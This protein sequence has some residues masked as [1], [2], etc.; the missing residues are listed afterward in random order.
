V[1]Q[2][3]IEEEGSNAG[4]DRSDDWSLEDLTAE[5]EAGY[6]ELE[7]LA[8]LEVPRFQ[9]DYEAE[10]EV[11]LTTTAIA[12]VQAY[13]SVVDPAGDHS[14]LGYFMPRVLR[15]A[16]ETG[17]W[18][19]AAETIV[20]L[21]NFRSENWSRTAF[22][23]EI[24]QAISIARFVTLLDQQDDNG[25][26]EFIGLAESLETIGLDLVLS[27]LAE[28]QTRRHR[29]VLCRVV[30]E[31]AGEE[32]KRL[33]AWIVDPRWHVVRNIAYILGQIGTQA[34]LPLLATLLEHPE[35]RV[36]HEAVSALGRID[37]WHTRSIFRKLLEH[38]DPKIFVSAVT[39][40]ALCRDHELSRLFVQFMTHPDFS[41][42][43]DVERRAI[44]RAIGQTGGN[45]VVRDLES[46][47]H[48]GSWLARNAEE[49]RQ[50]VARC[51]ADIGG[52][53][54][55]G[56]LERAL[57]SRRSPVRRAAEIALAVFDRPRGKAA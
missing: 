52:G 1:S 39:Q 57:Q 45:E 32:P 2:A 55:R 29:R 16:L 53:D 15:E 33:G 24:L 20:I 48:R 21:E 28:I 8:V 42:R 36:Q 43:S 18:H 3:S 25:L 31:W 54:A 51:L 37:P 22:Q 14:E 38:R 50:E 56:A 40:L 6:A 35:P 4:T 46:E 41:R 12:L 30:E 7:Q 26:A 34:T 19:E 27:V 9:R 5:V 44:Y 17:R 47:L 11:P 23:Q 49:H 10:H 13:L